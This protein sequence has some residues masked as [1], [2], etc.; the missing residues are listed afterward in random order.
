MNDEVINLLMEAKKNALKEINKV[1]LVYNEL[2]KEAANQYYYNLVRYN[3]Y[4]N[5]DDH[6]EL[7]VHPIIALSGCGVI[8]TTEG[9]KLLDEMLV[10]DG[11]TFDGPSNTYGIK[12]SIVEDFINKNNDK[13]KSSR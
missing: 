3:N 12:P 5:H 9:K 1:N 6:Y 7:I 4:N 10:N 2:W 11:F 13:T 8:L